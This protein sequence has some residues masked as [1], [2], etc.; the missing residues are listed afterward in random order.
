MIIWWSSYDDHHMTTIISS[1]FFPS[2]LHFPPFLV[3]PSSPPSP[4][5]MD[6]RPSRKIAIHH[7]HHHLHHHHHYHH[8]HHHVVF[9]IGFSF[10]IRRLAAPSTWSR[11]QKSSTLREYNIHL[12]PQ[13][14][15]LVFQLSIIFDYQYSPLLKEYMGRLRSVS[16]IVKNCTCT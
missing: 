13:Q 11:L 9:K 5:S 16:L 6:R 3:W 2:H 7:H 10:A 4:L 8:L 12:K 15:R 14:Q 1:Y